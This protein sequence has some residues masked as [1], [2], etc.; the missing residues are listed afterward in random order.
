MKKYLTLFLFLLLGASCFAQNGTVVKVS[1]TVVTATAGNVQ[2]TLTGAVPQAATGIHRTCSVAGANY[3]TE[4]AVIPVG[5]PNGIQGSFNA[6]GGSIT[7]LLLQPAAGS[8][9]TYSVTATPT[10]GVSSGAITGNF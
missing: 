1:N 10:V 4:D 7:Y 6:P 2:C 5:S 9:V 8:P 3:A